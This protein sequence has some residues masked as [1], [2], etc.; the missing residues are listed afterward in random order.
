MS[1]ATQRV[2]AEYFG[3]FFMQVHGVEP[4]PWQQRL[5]AQVIETGAFPPV[6]EA[7]TGSGKTAII[8]IALF[9]LAA[10]P[11]AVPRRVAFVTD[12]RTVADCAFTHV[13]RLRAAL[14]DPDANTTTQAVAQVLH[15]LSGG[16]PLNGSQSDGHLG[17]SWPDRPDV[18]WVTVSTVEAL[19]AALLMR[20]G[21]GTHRRMRPVR[22]GPGRQ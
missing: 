21:G 16:E 22:A 9:A 14:S 15:S 10:R 2:D 6:I 20:A 11:D 1:T 17:C 4:W 3:D 7:P 13:A 19:G 5:A 12:Q 8:D 18:P